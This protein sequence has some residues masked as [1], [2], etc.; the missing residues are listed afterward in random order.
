MLS[1][2]SK[3]LEN[4]VNEIA[5]LPGIGKRTAL[6]LTLHLIKT[7]A[8]EVQLLTDSISRLK[9]SLYYCKECYNISDKECCEICQH[10]KR[11]KQIICVVQDIRDI[12]AIENTHQYGGV[13]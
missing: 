7:P 8:E 6:R 9:T 5:K 10:P 3:Y 13:Y 4:A 12:I 2:Y 11:N 1:F